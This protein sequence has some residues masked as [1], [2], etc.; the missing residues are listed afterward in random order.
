MNYP[1]CIV[2]KEFLEQTTYG[3]ASIFF[4]S[5]SLLLHEIARMPLELACQK[6]MNLEAT[7]F[8]VVL[9]IYPAIVKL[10]DHQQELPVLFL[11]YTNT[12]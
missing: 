4:L 3:G 7:N 12:C 6:W 8:G 11:T 2:S 10:V 5:T 1:T 9:K